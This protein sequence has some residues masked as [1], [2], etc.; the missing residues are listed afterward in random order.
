VAELHAELSDVRA[1]ASREVSEARRLAQDALTALRDGEER[2][3]DLATELSQL[4]RGALEHERREGAVFAELMEV[5]SHLGGCFARLKEVEGTCAAGGAL[6][7]YNSDFTHARTC[8]HAITEEALA[9]SSARDLDYHAEMAHSVHEVVANYR[10]NDDGSNRDGVASSSAPTCSA[11]QLRQALLEAQSAAATAHRL[12]SLEEASLRKAR[13]ELE[14][15]TLRANSCEEFQNMKIIQ[16]EAEIDSLLTRSRMHSHL[17][18]ECESLRSATCGASH[19]SARDVH[20]SPRSFTLTD[21]SDVSSPFPAEPNVCRQKTSCGWKQVGLR[22]LSSSSTH[23]HTHDYRDGPLNSE[24]AGRQMLAHT[25]HHSEGCEVTIPFRGEQHMKIDPA[26]K[27]FVKGYKAAARR[28]QAV[29]QKTPDR[30][31]MEKPM[32]PFRV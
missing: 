25:V 30:R 21:S 9:Q 6:P 18:E 12:N 24:I 26:F 31:G 11:Q 1:E 7:A 4:R 3:R 2:G 23:G 5:S 29:R 13:T 32:P 20:A 28:A 27:E 17:V 19:D 14:D 10:M 8:K 15:V 22:N 16:L